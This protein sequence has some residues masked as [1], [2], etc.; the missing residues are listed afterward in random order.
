MLSLLAVLNHWILRIDSPDHSLRDV[1]GWIQ[2]T[3]GCE[4]L[5]V[6]PRYLLSN[7]AGPAALTLFHWQRTTPFQGELSVHCR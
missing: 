2:R 4:R 6:D 3:A 5:E 1:G 7:P